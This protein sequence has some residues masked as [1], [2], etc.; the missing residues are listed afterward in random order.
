[1]VL[2]APDFG[3]H[4]VEEDGGVVLD[5]LVVE[6]QFGEEGEVLAVHWVFEAVHLKHR[7]L[8][9]RVSVDLVAGRVPQR[10]AQRVPQH[11]SLDCVEGEAEL[12]EV[13]RVDVVVRGRVGGVVPRVAL[14]LSD[15]HAM[16]GLEFGQLEVHLQ[17]LLVH[18]LV[19]AV[20]LVHP[21]LRALL[22]ARALFGDLLSSGP[23]VGRGEPLVVAP[24]EGFEVH[25]VLI[26]ALVFLTPGVVI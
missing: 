20:L 4:V 14:V 13:E 18:S 12:A 16:H 15:A 6:E 1:M 5:V 21:L 25:V 11:L 22:L 26:A 3:E 24:V 10:A 19:L 2:A 8:R 7:Y 23:Q 17:R 9:V